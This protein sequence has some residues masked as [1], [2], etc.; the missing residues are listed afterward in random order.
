MTV[1]YYISNQQGI[2]LETI[3]LMELEFKI[4]TELE[5][6]LLQWFGHVNRTERNKV[7]DKGITIK[8]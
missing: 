5:V 3:F 2:K 4:L 6:K 7:T 8:I 1:M